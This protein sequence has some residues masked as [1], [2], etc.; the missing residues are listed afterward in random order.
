MC[1]HAV[2]CIDSDEH[3][4]GSVDVHSADA[5]RAWLKEEIALEGDAFDPFDDDVGIGASV[6]MGPCDALVCEDQ[7]AD[8]FYPAFTLRPDVSTRQPASPQVAALA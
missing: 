8:W 6:C 3:A 2:S 1:G 7:A 4:R 5:V